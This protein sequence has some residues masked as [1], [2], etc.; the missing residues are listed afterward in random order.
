[1]LDCSSRIVSILNWIHSSPATLAGIRD[2]PLQPVASD[3]L[4]CRSP[5]SASY[6]SSADQDF[7][8]APSTV[9]HSANRM[10]LIV[11]HIYVVKM[12][13]LHKVNLS[14]Q[15]SSGDMLATLVTSPRSP[16]Q[17]SCDWATSHSSSV[18]QARTF[19]WDTI[20]SYS[21]DSCPRCFWPAITRGK[22]TAGN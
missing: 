8:F 9:R 3:P 18:R 16:R 2:R 21:D 4:L 15:R 20:R 14:V 17:H 19:L 5:F 13:Q 12:Y 22:Q 10:V 1:M 6:Q 7:G 11:A